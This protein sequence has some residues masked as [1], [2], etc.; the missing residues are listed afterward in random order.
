MNCRKLSAWTLQAF[1]PRRRHFRLRHRKRRPAGGPAP[2]LRES[3]IALDP[4]SFWSVVHDGA[5]LQNGM[6]QFAA[7]DR[8]QVRQLYAYIRAGA[9]ETLAAGKTAPAGQ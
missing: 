3:Q 9:R 5:L 2:D 8:K 6:P 1:L 7:F 4:D